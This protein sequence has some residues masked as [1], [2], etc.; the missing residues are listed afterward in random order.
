MKRANSTGSIYKDTKRRNPYVAVINLGMDTTGK[1]KKKIIGSFPTY[2]E[3]QRSLEIYNTSTLEERK[4]N[5]ITLEELWEAHK[6]Q[7][8]RINKPG[9]RNGAFHL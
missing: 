6:D 4:S 3:A 2:W 7:C 1:R 5:Q 9:K 8:D